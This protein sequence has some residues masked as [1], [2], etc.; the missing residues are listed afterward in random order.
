VNKYNK[1][2][3][4]IICNVAETYYIFTVFFFLKNYSLTEI[5]GTSHT[6]SIRT[7]TTKEHEEIR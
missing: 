4:D 7:T 1:Y 5:I 2:E 3:K 6:L